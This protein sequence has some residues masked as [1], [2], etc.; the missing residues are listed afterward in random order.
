VQRQVTVEKSRSRPSFGN[1]PTG[2]QLPLQ[3]ATCVGELVPTDMRLPFI[4]MQFPHWA[5]PQR[6][7][8]WH[9][10]SK[11]ILNCTRTMWKNEWQDGETTA[12]LKIGRR[13]LDL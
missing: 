4:N 9:T 6:R 8:M 2:A 13:Q 10:F 3:G 12:K 7:H 11:L 5:A 1:D